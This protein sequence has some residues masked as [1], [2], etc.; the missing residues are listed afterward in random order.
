[1]TAP[2]EGAGID[3]M[4][5]KNGRIWDGRALWEVPA[6]SSPFLGGGNI[7]IGVL[8]V[9]GLCRYQHNPSNAENLVMF[10]VIE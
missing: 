10:K 1:M 4:K 5:L 7:R 9:D 2:A 8:D 6:A 3:M